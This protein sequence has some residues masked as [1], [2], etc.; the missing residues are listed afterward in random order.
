MSSGHDST[1]VHAA[2]ANLKGLVS[3]HCGEN[4]SKCYQCGKCSAGCPLAEEMDIAPSQILRMLQTGSKVYEEKVL[5]SLSIWLCLT[6]ETC[7]SRCPKEVDLPKIMDYL[8]EKSL[9]KNVVNP[10]AKDIVAFHNS[11][12][13]SV[14]YTGRLYE[15][16]LVSGYKMRTWHFLQ[17]VML[18]PKMFFKG[19]L[20]LLPHITRGF[21]KIKNIFNRIVG[22][23]EE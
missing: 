18:A 11:F 23:R 8:R 15:I 6:C 12:L 4:I 21:S 7:V 17:D 16:G 1:S 19:K 20:G 5:S 2:P 3:S 10:K 9:K 13:D 22:K 14:K